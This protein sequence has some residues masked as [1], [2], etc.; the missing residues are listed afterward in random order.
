[1]PCARPSKS[2]TERPARSCSRVARRLD[3]AEIERRRV[4]DA[5]DGHRRVLPSLGPARINLMV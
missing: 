4:S 2:G 3:S 1:M 5:V